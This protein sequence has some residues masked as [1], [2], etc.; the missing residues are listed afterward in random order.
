MK[1]FFS[2]FTASFFL[3]LAGT[4]AIVLDEQTGAIGQLGISLSFGLI[5]SVMILIF[6]KQSGAHMNPAVSL[7]ALLSGQLDRFHFLYYCCAQLLGAISA[8]ALLRSWFPSNT[9]LGATLPSGNVQV[10]FWLEVFMSFLLMLTILLV[11]F[12]CRKL[13]AAVSIG[14][15]VFA[16][17]YLGGP[18][19]GASM[20]PARSFGPAVVSGHFGY[21]WLYI[22]APISGMTGAYYFWKL[23][24]PSS[25]QK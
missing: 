17:A 1:K 10:A 21:L 13:F 7:V 9:L 15:V 19:S 11:S 20:N 5:V 8:S 18:I 3:V 22:V 24:F 6:G 25:P 4:G 23:L 16:E 14:F 12:N 2:E